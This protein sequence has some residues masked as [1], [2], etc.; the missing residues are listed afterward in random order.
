MWLVKTHIKS[1]I[2]IIILTFFLQGCKQKEKIIIPKRIKRYSV[3]KVVKLVT[4]NSLKYETLSVKKLSASYTNE[5]KSLSFRGSYKIRRD[6][7]IQLYAQKLAIPVGK[8]EVNLDSFKLV[9]FVQQELM[10]GKNSYLSEYI[11]MDV[12]YSVLQA[13]LSNKLFSFRQDTREKDFKDYV[14]DI[15]DD[16]Y[17]ISSIRDRKFK[18][19]NK[20]EER[21][22]RY[23]NRLDEGHVI[24]QDIYVDPD[25]FVVRRMVLNDLDTK[26]GVKLEFSKFEKVNDQWFPGS[27]DIQVIG[28]KKIELS[29]ELSKVS[30]DDEQN[31]GFSFSSKYKTKIIE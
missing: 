23:R 28:D 13:L 20:N 25:S 16:M 15:E 26:R 9:N 21:L 11:G 31:F 6:S 1:I 8:L 2:G 24:K 18:K 5:D 3:G 10:I 27:I 17:K 22:E 29:I 7:I 4:D 12:D 14:C 30:L 19:F